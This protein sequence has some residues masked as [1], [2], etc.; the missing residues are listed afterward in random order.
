ML[1]L[2]AT[3]QPHVKGGKDE[4]GNHGRDGRADKGVKIYFFSFSLSYLK[5]F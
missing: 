3:P 4:C 5:Y 2:V 1:P